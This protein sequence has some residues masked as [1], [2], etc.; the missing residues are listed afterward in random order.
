[1]PPASSFASSPCSASAAVGAVDR[2]GAQVVER[3]G[4]HVRDR[5]VSAAA[6]TAC[7]MLW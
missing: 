3:G 1:M 7:T 4:D 6:S 5:I 2:V